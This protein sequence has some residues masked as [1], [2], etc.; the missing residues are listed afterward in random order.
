MAS[1]YKCVK[2]K[3]G[4]GDKCKK[5]DLYR[6]KVRKQYAFSLKQGQNIV[7]FF[8]NFVRIYLDKLCECLVFLQVASKHCSQQ[9][10]IKVS[11]PMQLQHPFL[12]SETFNDSF[13]CLVHWCKPDFGCLWFSLLFL[14][15]LLARFVHQPCLCTQALFFK[16]VYI[17]Q[18]VQARIIDVNKY[19]WDHQFLHNFR[20]LVKYLQ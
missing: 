3:N 17:P 9:S 11:F 10:T 2:E 1:I 6:R 12:G 7:Y 5:S 15:N 8:P 19:Y 4:N 16:A 20:S 14:E 13:N 18:E